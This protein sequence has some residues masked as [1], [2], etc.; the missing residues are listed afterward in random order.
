MAFPIHRGRRLRAN[1]PLRELVRE[2]RVSVG[3]LIY[4]LFVV[5]GQGIRE[6]VASMPGVLR[7]SADQLAA[8]AKEIHDHGIPAV[9]LFG[10]PEAKDPEGSGAYDENGI[11]QRATRSIKDAVPELVVIGDVCLCEYTDH[12]HC[13]VLVG[14]N[15]ENDPT[16]PLLAE[17]AVSQANAGVDI[18]APSDMMD[19]RVAAI[20]GALDAE[21]FENTP[22]LSYAAKYASGFYGP[23]RDAAESAPAEGDRRGY[24]MD[25]GNAREALREVASDLDEGADL[26]LMKPALPYLDVIR[27]AREVFDVPLWAYQ[28]S[29]EF[30]MLCAAIERGWLERERVIRESLMSI[31]RAGAEKIITYFAKDVAQNALG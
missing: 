13:G 11:V 2:T 9:I 30:S 3:D 18:V 31:K 7:F 17:T 5:P 16:L 1:E 27:T 6:P 12:G 22:I 14:S 10:I 15:V 20:R 8:E 4:P 28:V 26:I 24:Q 21:G 25:P 23:F 29:G 19:G